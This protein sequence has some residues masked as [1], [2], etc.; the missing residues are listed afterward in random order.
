[1]DCIQKSVPTSKPSK[2]VMSKE[3]LERQKE[4]EIRNLILEVSF[5][6]IFLA[7]FLAM[8]FNSRDDRAFLYCDSVS[9][10]LNKEHDVDKVNEGHHLWNWIENAFFPFMYATKDWN[11]RDLNGSSK[12]VITLTSYRVG[13][14]RIRQHRLGN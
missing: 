13:P 10:L 8:V 12:T 5:Y 3:E 9:L 11:G 6:L 2:E 1:M 14:I 7:L 4:K